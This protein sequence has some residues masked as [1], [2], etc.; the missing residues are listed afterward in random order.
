MKN[1]PVK[2]EFN[3][4][5]LHGAQ[6]VTVDQAIDEHNTQNAGST[7][8]VCVFHKKKSTIWFLLGTDH[9]ILPLLIQ[10]FHLVELY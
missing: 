9:L 5:I 1:T 2:G 7:R 8:A 6:G 4:R 10:V 3:L